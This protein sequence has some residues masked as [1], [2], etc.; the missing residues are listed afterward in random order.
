MRIMV[1]GAGGF[2]GRHIVS[3]LLAKGHDVVGV[4]RSAGNLPDAF[5]SVDFD[6]LDL[7]T[8]TDEAD[9][10][11][12]LHNVDCVVNAAGIL[13]GRQMEAIH[14]D[15]PKALNSAASKVG[16]TQIVL[17]SAISARDNVTTDYSVA[18]L[19]GE[20]ALRDTDLDWTILRPSLVYGDGSYG[21]T[22]LIRGM[23]G[24]PFLTPIP[25][26]GEFPFTPI[27]VRDLAR[28]VT[29]ICGNEGFSKQVLEPVGPETINLKQLLGR[30][31][32]WL[33]MGRP[34]FV[35]VPMPLMRVAGRIGDFVGTG[36][37]STNSL[38][39]LAAG[40]AGDSVA[41]AKAIGFTPR[42]L[43]DALLARPAQV[44]DRWHAKLFF[45]GPAITTILVILWLASAWLGLF[46]GRVATQELAASFGSANH[47]IA[48]LQI[49]ASLADIA[50]A[51]L[52]L[53]DQK[54]RWSTGVQLLF[55]VGYT[56]VISAASPQLWL[57]P[58]GPL[59]K[60]LP[61]VML[62]AV[63]GAIKDNR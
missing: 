6:E 27:H 44:Q 43:D 63:H 55:V 20:V 36:P 17:I 5:P 51:A 38:S 59:L 8:A 52:V 50:I 61:I 7:A 21:G 13:R 34:R 19:N 40:N 48:P 12:R 9:W 2:I 18:K 30:Y 22:S 28:S 54:G 57:D 16:V 41:Y 39:Q 56:V 47:M 14:V 11:D 42:R 1:L 29:L 32:A 58:M 45:L 37:I 23:A 53:F 24:I 46:H 25:G 3:D 15:F 35:P 49:G 62:I 31:R 33:G 4:V 60:N 26:D 10:C